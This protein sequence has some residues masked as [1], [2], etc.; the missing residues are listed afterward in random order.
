[1]ERISH[2]FTNYTFNKLY[3]EIWRVLLENSTKF[4][5]LI[6]HQFLSDWCPFCRMLFYRIRKEACSADCWDREVLI[7]DLSY[8]SSSITSTD[9]SKKTQLLERVVFSGL[10]VT[11]ETH[12]SLSFRSPQYYIWFKDWT[13]VKYGNV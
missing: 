11:L 8:Y 7:E 1:M 5:Y 6:F 3:I 10:F 4:R 2:V 12:G 9:F 13:I